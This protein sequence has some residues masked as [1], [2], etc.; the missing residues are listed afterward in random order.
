MRWHSTKSKERPNHM[1]TCIC[2]KLRNAGVLY[3][4]YDSESD[5]FISLDDYGDRYHSNEIKAWVA[6]YE[7]ISDCKESL[8]NKRREQ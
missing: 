3:A 4:Y 1:D 5:Q 6:D 7:L 2:I 8:A